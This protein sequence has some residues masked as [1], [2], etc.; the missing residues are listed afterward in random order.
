MGD[1]VTAKSVFLESRASVDDVQLSRL[2]KYL[3]IRGKRM[4]KKVKSY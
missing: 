3:P 2:Y 4:V 1:P